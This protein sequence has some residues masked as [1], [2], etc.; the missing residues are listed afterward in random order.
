[1]LDHRS[2][3]TTCSSSDGDSVGAGGA[4][5]RQAEKFTRCRFPAGPPVD[6]PICGDIAYHH[7]FGGTVA[8][9][10]CAAFFRRTIV[11]QKSYKCR[12]QNSCVLKKMRGRTICK[13]CRFRACLEVGMTMKAVEPKR[14]QSAAL[15]P[16]D[17]SN[18]LQSL[19]KCLRS[20]FVTRYKATIFVYGDQQ[21]F[22]NV[23]NTIKTAD[24]MLKANNAEIHVLQSFL[25]NS[26]L[27]TNDDKRTGFANQMLQATLL[28]WI[29]CESLF[30]NIKQ[31]SFRTNRC[32]FLDDS[33]IPL[34]WETVLDYYRGYHML[35]PEEVARHAMVFYE[36][37]RDL[38]EKMHSQR[39][40]EVEMAV[41]TLILVL[42]HAISLN[43]RNVDTYRDRLNDLFKHLQRHYAENYDDMAIRFGNLILFLEEL[44][45]DISKT[46]DEMLVMMRLSDQ[47]HLK[48]AGTH[49]YLWQNANCRPIESESV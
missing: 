47:A 49:N 16:L 23:A 39:V 11:E 4:G 25:F 10:G 18:S 35:F 7:H 30:A 14:P 17:S 21:H 41:F 38:A 9:N 40:D 34:D 6:C 43:G 42:K 20:N 33:Y 8:C 13:D 12:K 28:T 27:I 31:L 26:G 37:V 32:Y 1:M 2:P 44:M 15:R 29:T 22:K 5:G 36:K 46:R 24:S 48:D 45:G 3:A 19:L